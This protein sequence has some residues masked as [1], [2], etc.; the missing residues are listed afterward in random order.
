MRARG[1]RAGALPAQALR[2]IGKA[3]FRG[4]T[5]YWVIIVYCRKNLRL[6]SKSPLR[7]AERTLNYPGLAVARMFRP[8]SNRIPVMA[9]PRC[10]E[11]AGPERVRKLIAA[12]NVK[13]IRKRKMGS[14]VE[15]QLLEYGDDSRTPCKYG[16]P[17]KL[18]RTCSPRLRQPSRGSC[19]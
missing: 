8:Q 10:I 11:F 6:L 13:V 4:T 7:L 14:I 16:N 5:I 1:V 3:H 18:V 19:A 12:S 2:A 9:G 17:Q 15:I